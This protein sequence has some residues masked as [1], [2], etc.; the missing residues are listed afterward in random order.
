MASMTQWLD[1]NREFA[2][3]YRNTFKVLP[4]SPTILLTC[5]DARVDPAHTLG[6]E[7]GEATVLRGPGARVTADIEQDIC[8]LWTLASQFLGRTPHIS[9][10]IIQHTDCG[11]ERLSIPEFRTVISQRLGIS[12]NDVAAL[13]VAD[14]NAALK[15]DIERLRRSPIVPHG[16]TVSGYLYHVEDGFVREVYPPERLHEHD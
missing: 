15:A 1:R 16:L 12:E 9:L 8:I 6:L 14:H 2:R 5:P 10:A 13:S 3:N 11:F 4:P 7:L